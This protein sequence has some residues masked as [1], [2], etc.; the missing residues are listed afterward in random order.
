M[1][2]IKSNVER[3]N[4]TQDQLQYFDENQE[5]MKE[6]IDQD[7]DNFESAAKLSPKTLKKHSSAL[8]PQKLGALQSSS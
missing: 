6:E 8:I 2:R 4:L 1:N 5:E 3:M 7:E